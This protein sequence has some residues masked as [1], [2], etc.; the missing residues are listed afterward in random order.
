[1]KKIF[2]CLLIVI[3]SITVFADS[4]DFRIGTTVDTNEYHYK[5]IGEEK[6]R[7]RYCYVSALCEYDLTCGWT[8]YGQAGTNLVGVKELFNGPTAG[9]KPTNEFGI[10]VKRSLES[11]SAFKVGA[12]AKVF[13]GYSNYKV[14]AATASASTDITDSICAFAKVSIGY[15][16]I[17]D[18]HLKNECETSHLFNQ[19]GC[20]LTY[21]F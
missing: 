17:D 5:F 14:L 18:N 12:E 19:I 10:G 2:L 6:V 4:S 20:G 13:K 21:S 8:I 16:T 15:Q 11:N 3:V 9:K 7:V 1:M